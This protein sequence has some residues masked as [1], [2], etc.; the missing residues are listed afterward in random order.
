MNLRSYK[1]T[2]SFNGQ[3]PWLFPGPREFSPKNQFVNIKETLYNRTGE[4][5]TLFKDKK[6]E[7]NAGEI[8]HMA[9]RNDV[10]NN[11]AWMCGLRGDRDQ[12]SK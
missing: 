10:Y 4:F 7:K 3:D 2:T 1:N 12:R 11:M 8:M 5:K 9:R 6:A